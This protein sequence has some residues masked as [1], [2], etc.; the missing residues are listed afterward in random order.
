M[1]TYQVK[2]ELDPETMDLVLPVPDEILQEMGWGLDDK[3]EWIDNN[4]GTFTLRKHY[5]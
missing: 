5:A 3:L 1:T 4:D 2:L